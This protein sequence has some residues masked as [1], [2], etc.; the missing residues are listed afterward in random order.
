VILPVKVDGINILPKSLT[1][2]TG[3]PEGKLTVAMTGSDSGAKY[4]LASSDIGVA[5]VTASGSVKGLT[6]GTAAIAATVVGYPAVTSVC[7]VRV[8]K[9]PPVITVSPNQNVALNGEAVFT[10]S[11]APQAYGTTVEIKAD[12]DGD[13]VYEQTVLNKEGADFKQKYSEVKT[14]TISFKAK[15]T[16]G[17]EEIVTRKVTVGAPGAPVISIVNPSKDTSVNVLSLIIRFTY[18]DTL[19]KIDT[20]LDSTVILLAGSNKVKAA[21]NN[22]GGVGSDEVT[23][24][25]DTTAPT[26]AI[27]GPAAQNTGVA[28]FSLAG[29]AGD[30]ESGLQSINITGALAGNG[31]ATLTAGDW[32]KGGLTLAEGLNTL[33]ATGLDKAGNSKTASIAVT[34]DSKKPGAPIVTAPAAVRAGPI[35]WTWAKANGD[36]SGKFKLKI[37]GGPEIDATLAEYS[38]ATLVEGA[39]YGLAVKETDSIA[40]DGPWSAEK[41]VLYDS[42]KPS[43]SISATA[44]P[45]KTPEWKWVGNGGIG[46]FRWHY[47]GQAAG[48]AGTGISAMFAPTTLATG[49]YNLCVQE[50]DSPEWGEEWGT[51]SCATLEVDKTGPN[52]SA[53]QYPD[54]YVTNQTALTIGFNADGAPKTYAC[55]LGTDKAQNTCT[56]TASDALGNVTT[57]ERKIWRRSNVVFVREGATGLGTTFDEAFGSLRQALSLLGAGHNQIWIMEGTYFMTE[58]PGPYVPSGVSIYGGFSTNKN[59][60][61]IT[62]RS[63]STDRTILSSLH[64]EA[65]ENFSREILNIRKEDESTIENVILD[66]MTITAGYYGLN[67]LNASAITLSNMQF[68]KSFASPIIGISNSA[69]A[70]NDCDFSNNTGEILSIFGNTVTINRCKFA[71]NQTS[72]AAFYLAQGKVVVNNS[73]FQNSSDFTGFQNWIS[74]HAGELT[75]TLEMYNNTIQ[76]LGTDPGPIVWNTG[77]RFYFIGS[78]NHQ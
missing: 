16:E 37:N 69:V 78:G 24:L 20:L 7:S 1:L 68:T 67:I 70:I 72:S 22:G 17:N 12:M 58:T 28:A 41:K 11:V 42:K 45:T 64:A 77:E 27:T 51:E 35:K 25:A 71:N 2:Y 36:G 5:T 66:G 47:K 50:K 54:G 49:S 61:S 56:L 63:F 43:P 8:V 75:S 6:P 9:D 60:G 15:D 52:I 65:G 44:T 59:Q 57:V 33:V 26:I 10:V 73:T 48:S 76:G 23:I 31:S 46:T 13:D 3:G 39:V 40:G 74:V 21:R 55:Q 14:T 19:L 30:L 38:L 62:E 29:T 18:K 53:I 34:L 32:S 4:T